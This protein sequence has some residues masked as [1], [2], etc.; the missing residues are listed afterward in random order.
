MFKVRRPRAML[1]LTT[2]L[3][4]AGLQWYALRQKIVTVSVGTYQERAV[5][6]AAA[7]QWRYGTICP[8]HGCVLVR[9]PNTGQSAPANPYPPA[10]IATMMLVELQS[11]PRKLALEWL[12]YAMAAASL[13]FGPGLMRR[14]DQHKD[15]IIADVAPA[16]AACW[17]ALIILVS[18]LLMQ[19]Y[20]GSL[21][22]TYDGPGAIVYSTGHHRVTGKTAETV[23]YRSV[24]EAVGLGPVLIGLKTG[25]AVR[26]PGMTYALLIAVGGAV[27]YGVPAIFIS[28]LAR[29]WRE[30]RR[31]A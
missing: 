24:I 11:V 25:L 20:G 15:S 13:L 16:F 18:P 7:S 22:S 6:L 30:D 1:L 9:T 12:L 19:G 8:M 10:E 29:R 23:S 31:P 26:V 14:F 21:Y 27:V 5:E 3:L 2:A 28:L 4:L 17:L